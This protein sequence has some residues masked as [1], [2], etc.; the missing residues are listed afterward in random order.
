MFLTL[1]VATHVSIRTCHT[2]TAPHGYGFAELDQAG[3]QATLRAELAGQ[4]GQPRA[5]G[6]AAGSYVVHPAI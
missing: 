3:H 1:F 6:I 2:S 5:A 4:A